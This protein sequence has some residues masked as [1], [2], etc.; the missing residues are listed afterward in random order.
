VPWTRRTPKAFSIVTSSPQTSSSAGV[1]PEEAGTAGLHDTLANIASA[2]GD[3]AE[4][5]KEEALLHDQPDL[6]MNLDTRHGDVAAAHGQIQKARDFYEK[7][8]QVAQR[9]Q[10]KDSE[11]FYLG[12]QAYALAMFGQSKKATETANAALALA[13]SYNVK[14]YTAGVLA[15]GGENRKALDAAAQATH[16]RPDDTFVREVQAPVVQAAIALNTG[17]PRKAIELLKPAL[18]YDKA[19]TVPIYVRALAHLKVGQGADAAGEFQRI[20]ALSNFAP[21]DL[22]MPFARLG[23]ARTYVLQGD[24]ARAI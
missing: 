18:S 23:L 19:T 17:D 4:M 13:P 6:E 10:L 24:T 7:G 3:L 8:R 21:T 2:Q 11:A 16:D 9:L 22:L 5:E 12:A 14:F 1:T 20:L 15:L